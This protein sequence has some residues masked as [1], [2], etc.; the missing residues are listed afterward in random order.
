MNDIKNISIEGQLI[1]K[2]LLCYEPICVNCAVYENNCLNDLHQMRVQKDIIFIFNG[3]KITILKGFLFDGASI[4]QF[5]WSTTG[6][7]FDFRFLIAALIHDALYASELLPRKE[8]D[9]IFLL[10]LKYYGVSYYNRNKIYLGVRIGGGNVWK[11]HTQE[12][13]TEARNFV[14]TEKS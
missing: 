8:A 3:Y 10:L 14:K 13:I 12:S 2:P 6:S 5:F 7:P 9:E 4:P 1:L 11:T